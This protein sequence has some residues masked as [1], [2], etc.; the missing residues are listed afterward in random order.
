MIEKIVNQHFIPTF[1]V[2]KL[3]IGCN[4][5]NVKVMSTDGEKFVV[6]ELMSRRN[7]KYMFK[8]DVTGNSLSIN[9][10]K[11]PRIPTLKF[12]LQ[13]FIPKTFIG[14]VIISN[15]NG[16]IL[17]HDMTCQQLFITDNSGKIVL[18]DL[19]IEKG[20]FIQS[21]NGDIKMDNIRSRRFYLNS[22]SG[23]IKAV[24]LSGAGSVSSSTGYVQLDFEMVSGNIVVND[25][26]GTVKVSMPERDSYNFKLQ[27]KVAEVRAPRTSLHH[28]RLE[29]KEGTVGD[30]PQ[31][32][33]NVQTKSGRIKVK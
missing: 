13:I 7:L 20:F 2:D 5:A 1:D 15:H 8:V 18:D 23:M 11:Y 24:S 30:N 22:Y 26:K 31:Y 16:S 27:S 4:N 19:K 10:E 14:D 32:Q 28:D 3:N 21:R 25:T 12:E 9:Q 29:Y 33:L 6:R 17:L